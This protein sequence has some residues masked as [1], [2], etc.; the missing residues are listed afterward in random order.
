MQ[1]ETISLEVDANAARAYVSAPE[2]TRRKLELLLNLRL[3]ELTSRS[4]RSL[5]EIM[6]DIGLTAEARGLTPDILQ[7]LLQDE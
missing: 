5:T 1:T 4:G 2:D 6:E 7:A 3:Q